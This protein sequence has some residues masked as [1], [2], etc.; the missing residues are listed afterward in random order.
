VS[1][2]KEKSHSNSIDDAMM[3]DEESLCDEEEDC[4]ENGTFHQFHPANGNLHGTYQAIDQF[5]AT[6]SIS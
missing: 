6:S 4:E 1:S 2:E 5:T 3:T